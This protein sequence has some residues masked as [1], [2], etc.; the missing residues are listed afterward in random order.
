ML[1]K[2]SFGGEK[3]Q[4]GN[5]KYAQSC[6]CLVRFLFRFLLQWYFIA[7]ITATRHSLETLHSEFELEFRFLKL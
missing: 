6:A 7:A 4:Q 5:F 3:P 2:V 1:N